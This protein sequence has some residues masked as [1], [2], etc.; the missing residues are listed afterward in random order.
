LNGHDFA[1][2]GFLYGLGAN[3]QGSCEL[4]IPYGTRN[5]LQQ[6]GPG[7]ALP[8]GEGKTGFADLVTNY[9]GNGSDLW[10]VEPISVVQNLAGYLGAYVEVQHYIA[11][12]ANFQR[13]GGSKTVN[14]RQHFGTRKDL[15][16][17]PRRFVPGSGMPHGQNP[18][19]PPPIWRAD[20]LYAVVL[21]IAG[22]VPIGVMAYEVF[23]ERLST[24][25]PETSFALATAP[26]YAA[27]RANWEWLAVD[28]NGGDEDIITPSINPPF[29]YPTTPCGPVGCSW[30]WLDQHAP[31]IWVGVA[32]GVIVT[33][34]ACAIGGCAA[35]A[36][37][38]GAVRVGMAVVAITAA[39]STY[40][41]VARAE[42]VP[43]VRR[44]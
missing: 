34:G 9:L 15:W 33:V 31:P 35:A 12:A 4:P 1:E 20:H 25:K 40:P 37:G 17:E 11:A 3:N 22:S 27:L 30:A 41:A 28:V 19:I 16:S 2:S 39:A 26:A 5:R 18:Y 36:I 14:T 44:R 13:C 38:I 8:F 29:P 21:T 32:A 43:I 23:K 6:S 7:G 10:E 42:D 24:P